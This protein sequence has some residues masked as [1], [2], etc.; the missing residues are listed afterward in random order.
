M[1]PRRSACRS[2]L[3]PMRLQQAEESPCTRIRRR[4]TLSKKSSSSTS[5]ASYRI[6][7]ARADAR[8]SLCLAELL[9]LRTS[10]S[11]LV[12]RPP[13]KRTLRAKG[14]EA[15]DLYAQNRRLH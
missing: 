11:L 15:E 3:P 12:G 8:P 9:R 7:N 5:V 13:E 10:G 1:A 6:G 2:A 4:P 14:T